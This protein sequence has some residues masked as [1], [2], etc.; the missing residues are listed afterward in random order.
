[1][2]S[3]FSYVFSHISLYGFF[4]GDLQ[5]ICCFQ[6]PI[7][8]GLVTPRVLRLRFGDRCTERLIEQISDPGLLSEE[9][10]LEALICLEECISNQVF[11]YFQGLRSIWFG[12]K[13]RKPCFA[14]ILFPPHKLCVSLLQETRVC[15]VDRGL[16]RVLHPLLLRQCHAKQ[17]STAY[18]PNPQDGDTSDGKREDSY[19][20]QYDA[21]AP[22]MVQPQP[23]TDHAQPEEGFSFGRNSNYSMPPNLDSQS[24]STALSR[25]GWMYIA[26]RNAKTPIDANTERPT[27]KILQGQVLKIL[28]H[29]SSQEKARLDMHHLGVWKIAGDYLISESDQHV[30]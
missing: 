11:L 26:G 8:N 6:A 22:N 3:R 9:L 27:I 4:N 2:L 10:L 1:M 24:V 14:R 30:M 12:P 19:S 16:V 28:S 17:G 29:L 13:P 21:A 25:R 23:M 20:Q 7:T 18:L 5:G 15:A